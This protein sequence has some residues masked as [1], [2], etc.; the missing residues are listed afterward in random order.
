MPMRTFI[1]SITTSIFLTSYRR[2]LVVLV[3][4][5]GMVVSVVGRRACAPR[6]WLYYTDCVDYAHCV[7]NIGYAPMRAIVRVI[8]VVT[9]VSNRP[10]WWG[11][12]GDDDYFSHDDWA[13]G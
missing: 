6:P 8:S 11:Y 5:I 13:D 3:I 1:A 9:V 10:R 2:G 12:H 4:W 7:G